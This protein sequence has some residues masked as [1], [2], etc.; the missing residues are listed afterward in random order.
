[1][2]LSLDVLITFPALSNARVVI[3]NAILADFFVL[4]AFDSFSLLDGPVT[5]CTGGEILWI[6][7]SPEGTMTRFGVTEQTELNAL[8]LRHCCC[9]VVFELVVKNKMKSPRTH[10]HVQIST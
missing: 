8:P 6:Q 1:M 7:I 3:T 9:R 10:S 5:V 4:G 2:G